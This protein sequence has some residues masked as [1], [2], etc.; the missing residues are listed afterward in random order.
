MR[1]K[2]IPAPKPSCI[3]RNESGGPGRSSRLLRY[4]GFH[5]FL[6]LA[7]AGSLITGAAP[8]AHAHYLRRDWQFVNRAHHA[9]NDTSE[10]AAVAGPRRYAGELKSL[11]FRANMCKGGFLAMLVPHRRLRL[12]FVGEM[13][14]LYWLAGARAD[15]PPHRPNQLEGEFQ[16]KLHHALASRPD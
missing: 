11:L 13:L 9:M 16:S 12:R 10:F 3:S 2:S 7:T 4:P 15:S 14:L 8:P 5:E 6:T 1:A